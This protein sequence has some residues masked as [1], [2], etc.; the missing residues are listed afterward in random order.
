MVKRLLT[1]LRGEKAVP[2]FPAIQAP[3]YSPE[4]RADLLATLATHPGFELLISEL[5]NKRLHSELHMPSLKSPRSLDDLIY[6]AVEQTRWD[7]QRRERGWLEAQVVQ[8]IL[9]AAPEAVAESAKRS[10][11]SKV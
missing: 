4:E 6:N 7:T 11:F 5:H 1:W 10:A 8:A 9:T 3:T 2:L